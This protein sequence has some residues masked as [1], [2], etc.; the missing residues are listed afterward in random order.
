[1]TQFDKIL[2]LISSVYP[3]SAKATLARITG[4][5]KS[6]VTRWSRSGVVPVAYYPALMDWAAV[7]VLE[8]AMLEIIGLKVADGVYIRA[9][10][11]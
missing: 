6:Q 1:M 9:T 4:K 5:N 10:A 8:D 2:E 3:N 7:F 11:W